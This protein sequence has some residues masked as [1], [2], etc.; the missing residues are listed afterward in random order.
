MAD[1]KQD[2]QKAIQVKKA[3]MACPAC[4]RREWA[5]SGEV[6]LVPDPLTTVYLL[7]CKWCGYVRMHDLDLLVPESG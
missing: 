6:Q 1:E 2:A 4:G 3:T 7:S 5:S